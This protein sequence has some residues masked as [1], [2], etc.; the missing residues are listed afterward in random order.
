MFIQ[1]G[2]RVESLIIN[3]RVWTSSVLVALVV[4]KILVAAAFG[5][6]SANAIKVLGVKVLAKVTVEALLA[7]LAA[8]SV[9]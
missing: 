9:L 1:S 6:C 5:R 3:F 2:F 4:A 8:E 7:L